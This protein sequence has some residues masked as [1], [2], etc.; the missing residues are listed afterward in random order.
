R[1]V[2]PICTLH[3]LFNDCLGDCRKDTA[4]IRLRRVSGPGY[5]LPRPFAPPFPTALAC[6]V[7]GRGGIA[8]SSNRSTL[9]YHRS[10][11]PIRAHLTPPVP[12]RSHLVTDVSPPAP[13]KRMRRL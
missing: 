10:P 9:P 7:A 11:T 3:L 4:E 12:I 2:E 6:R 13:Q 1:T 5:G 8:V